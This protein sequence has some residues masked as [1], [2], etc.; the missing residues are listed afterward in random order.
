MRTTLFLT[1]TLLVAC[2][3]KQENS[4]KAP[5][6][7]ATPVA[8]NAI[9]FIDN[10]AAD[11]EGYDTLYSGRKI[12]VT[13]PVILVNTEGELSANLGELVAPFSLQCGFPESERPKVEN[14]ERGKTATFVGTVAHSEPDGYVLIELSNC[15]VSGP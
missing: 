2:G 11:P 12:A 3:T 5:T 10:Y 9:E 4:S 6:P 14:L 1:L 15:V 8:L 13:G 7:V